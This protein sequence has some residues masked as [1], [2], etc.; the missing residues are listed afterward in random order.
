MPCVWVDH[1]LELA[2]KAERLEDEGPHA[3]DS[4]MTGDAGGAAAAGHR[5]VSERILD[6]LALCLW[7]GLA[8]WEHL[9][10]EPPPHQD[11]ELVLGQL[12][13]KVLDWGESQP[14]AGVVTADSLQAELVARR[15]GIC[16][17]QLL[18][19]LLNHAGE[20]VLRAEGG[21][22]G[23]EGGVEGQGV[24]IGGDGRDVHTDPD[25]GVLSALEVSQLDWSSGDPADAGQCRNEAAKVSGCSRVARLEQAKATQ[26]D[27]ETGLG[28]LIG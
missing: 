14:V 24:D 12:Q 9:Q 25:K 28:V 20:D 27:G 22:F 15:G 17:E 4:I 1:D 13:P 3:V 19:C 18:G 7:A 11:H 10:P 16:N 5:M 6:S 2:R 21:A 26:G 8:R 23:R